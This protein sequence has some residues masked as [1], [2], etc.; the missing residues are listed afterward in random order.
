MYAFR[1]KWIG[2]EPAELARK[3]N[4]NINKL[5]FQLTNRNWFMQHHNRKQISGVIMHKIWTK[6]QKRTMIIRCALLYVFTP[7]LQYWR[8]SIWKHSERMTVV[9]TPGREWHFAM[10]SAYTVILS[11]SRD[12]R[13]TWRIVWRIRDVSGTGATGLEAGRVQRFMKLNGEQPR[14]HTSHLS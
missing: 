2:H 11:R 1:G 9:E 12:V 14:T 3:Q 10:H 4:K 5:L 7:F 13:R 6:Y 8:S